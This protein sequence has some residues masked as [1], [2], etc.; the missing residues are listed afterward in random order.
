MS[1]ST[2]S[3]RVRHA[4]IALI[5]AGSLVAAL[6]TCSGGGSGRDSNVVPVAFAPVTTSDVLTQAEIDDIVEQAAIS[7]DAPNI[8]VAVVDRI[9]NI[10]RVWN[11]NPSSQIGDFDNKIAVSVARTAAFLSHSQAPLTSRTGQFISTFHF[12]VVFD[13]NNYTAPFDPTATAP[14]RP[15][16]GV[17]NTGQGPLWQID[18][19]DRGVVYGPFDAGQSLP[20]L[21]NPD[22]STPSPGLTALPG[23]VPLYKRM[24]VV[25]PG[26]VARRLVGAI[27]VYATEGTLGTGNPLPEVSEYAALSGSRT[28]HPVAGSGP[29]AFEDYTF[30]P[31]PPEG[32]V[33]LV[34]ILLPYLGQ[35]SPPAGFGP[36][37]NDGMTVFTSGG[38]GSVDP[39]FDLISPRDSPT[40]ATFTMNEVRTLV[41]QTA[42]AALEVHAA[43]RLPSTSPCSM[44]IGITDTNG[45]ILALYRMNDA[46]LFSVDIAL[47]KARNSYHYSNPLAIDL[48]GPR[49]GQHPLA[50]IVPAGTAVTCRTL[51]FLSQP[52]FPPGIDGSG[53]PGPLYDLALENRKPVRFDQMGY[54]TPAVN[55]SGVIFF[56]GSAPLYRNGM[57]IG[58]IGVSGDGVEQDDL[59]TTLGIQRAQSILGFQME[60]PANIRCDNFTYQGVTIPYAKFPQNPGG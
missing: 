29:P 8:S 23:G 5:C 14:T 44:V 11:R 20:Q 13:M 40:G 26:E 21:T 37:A 10:L 50:G 12:P 25:A 30:G 60:P 36:G 2:T 58:G 32:A 7:V 34:G 1:W 9:G 6:T 56:P 45:E 18:A 28:P 49:A 39:N 53:V 27:G 48:D 33:Y 59:V 19:S 31:I 22:G 17:A 38:S 41:D 57:L 52:F 16:L 42:A 46:T 43:I 54:A 55:Q 4:V 15:T 24:T 47:T 3:S 35:V 51:G